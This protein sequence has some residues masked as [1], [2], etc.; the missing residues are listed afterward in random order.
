[1]AEITKDS[2]QCEKIILVGT[3]S[4]TGA[5]RTLVKIDQVQLYY[6]TGRIS[7]SS[8]MNIRVLTL[9]YMSFRRV[10]KCFLLYLLC[11]D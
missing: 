3:D 10:G 6:K 7:F 5:K 11:S 8:H 9:C 2:K 4:N 1:M